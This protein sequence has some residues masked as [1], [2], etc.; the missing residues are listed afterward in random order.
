MTE[1]PDPRNAVSAGTEAVKDLRRLTNTDPEFVTDLAM[2][3]SKLSVALAATKR[4]KDALTTAD[5]AV[6]LRRRLVTDDPATHEPHLARQ[7]YGFASMLLVGGI[8][9]AQAAAMAQESLA[10]YRRLLERDPAG[11]R[12][13]CQQATLALT[14][15]LKTGGMRR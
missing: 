11:F 1:N 8:A 14:E 12:I 7:L 6:T 10:I 2:A 13:E 9:T 3:L 15:L 5:E 4:W